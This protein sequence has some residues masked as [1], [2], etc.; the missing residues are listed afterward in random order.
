MSEPLFLEPIEPSLANQK[1][2][3]A[4]KYSSSIFKNSFSKQKKSFEEFSSEFN[5]K[6]HSLIHSP[7]MW[8]CYSSL[9]VGVIYLEEG[10]KEAEA[11]VSIFID[12][13]FQNKKIGSRALQK[14]ISLFFQ[15]GIKNLVAFVKKENTVA[16][17]F[18]KNLG[19]KNEGFVNVEKYGESHPAFRLSLSN[20]I[21]KNQTFIIA[22]IGS[23]FCLGGA[24]Q[25]LEMAKRMMREAA[26]AGADAVK[27]QLFSE[28]TIYVP[29][30]GVAG[31]LKQDINEI[32]KQCALDPQLIP[33]LSNY[34]KY[35]GIE[36]LCSSFSQEDFDVIDPYVQKHKIASYELRHIRLLESAA[37]SKKPLF[38]ST[39]AA[40]EEDIKWATGFFFEK[41]G[42]EITLM[43]CTAQ[44]PA[45]APGL[46]LRCIQTLQ[47]VFKVPVGL[48]DH[49]Q[50]PLYA[51]L[52][53]VTLGASVI[54]KHVT[55]HSKLPGPDNSFAINF[56]ELKQMCKGIRETEIILG[57]AKKEIFPQEEELAAFARRGIQA[58]K[59]IQAGEL[60]SENFNIGILRPGTQ[61]L[62]IH[63]K[64]L[65]QLKGKRAAK[66][67]SIGCGLQIDDIEW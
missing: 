45:E 35:I 58:L 4:L 25:N 31:Y 53:A 40:T 61:R 6:F 34:A 47:K 62:G 11:Q 41:G 2:I 48:S 37:R 63:P 12:S 65:D 66:D 10:F 59:P 38:L 51:P 1:K 52:A 3:Y 32:F 60:L 29:N 26:D 13:E 49:S 17:S 21:H 27:F 46:N 54:E 42:K 56:E 23:N 15:K 9:K 44:Y 28:K 18:F 7:P 14:A 43:H 19:F 5:T 16:L 57:L 67:I 36:F 64:H 20:Q 55:M 24:E 39:G 50:H 30:A 22:E 8:V 33:I